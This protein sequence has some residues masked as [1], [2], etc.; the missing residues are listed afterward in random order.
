MILSVIIPTYNRAQLLRRAID[1]VISQDLPPQ[2]K[3][4][5][6]I[7]VDDGSTDG[8]EG[9]IKNF[10]P[11]VKY[12]CQ[13]NLGVSSAR[14]FG[15][16]QAS[17][18]W[19][20]LL[21]SDDEWLPTKLLRQFDA[22]DESALLVCHTEEIWIRN[23]VR[24]N[25]MIKHRKYGGEI[26]EKCLPLCAMSPSSIIIHKAVFEKIGDFDETLP[27]CEDYDLWLRL[28]AHYR[29]TYVEQ[30]CINKYGGHEDQLS[31]AFWGMDRFR[32]AALS[33]LLRETDPM[34][35]LTEKQ[36]ISVKAMLCKKNSILLKGA[37]KHQNWD[38]VEQSEK[39]AKEFCL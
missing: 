38:L 26:F 6:I 15:L 5:E 27:A 3:E 39:L 11:N 9:V 13:Q 17:G 24:V 30:P 32:I 4:M 36:K 2:V 25:Q 8:T 33:K 10:Y 14:N 16:K 19:L 31:R 37:E 29:V 21:D 18:E 12:V 22:L 1:S 28:A 34:L 35:V 23:G 20:A 7:V